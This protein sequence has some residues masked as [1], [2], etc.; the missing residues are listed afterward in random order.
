MLETFFWDSMPSWHDCITLILHICQV[1]IYVSQKIKSFILCFWIT[2]FICWCCM[3]LAWAP[4]YH[5]RKT[6]TQYSQFIATWLTRTICI[7]KPKRAWLDS[8]SL[9]HSRLI[10]LSHFSCA[11]NWSFSAGDPDKL[12][13]FTSP[14]LSFS[15]QSHQLASFEWFVCFASFGFIT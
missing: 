2:C 15:Q 10:C 1:P 8:V 5:G 7:M 13:S 4:S 12:G 11:V 6:Q 14:V 9:W 3:W